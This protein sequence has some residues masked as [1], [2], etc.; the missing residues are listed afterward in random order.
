MITLT[1]PQRK[2]VHRLFLD[3]SHP[4]RYVCFCDGY[5]A[6]RKRVQCGFGCVMLQ[7]VDNGMWLGIEPD[8]YTHS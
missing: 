4:E 8:G 7:P 5:R 6:F 1:K 3:Y 2:A